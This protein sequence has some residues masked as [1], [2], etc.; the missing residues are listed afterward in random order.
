MWSSTYIPTH[1]DNKGTRPNIYNR[2]RPRD[3]HFDTRGTEENPR[4]GHYKMS[5][6]WV[7][8]QDKMQGIVHRTLPRRF[9]GTEGQQS[10]HDPWVWTG[11]KKKRPLF[12]PLRRRQVKNAVFGKGL[13]TQGVEGWTMH[14]TLQTKQFVRCERVQGQGIQP[15]IHALQKSL[16]S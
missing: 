12:C 5:S 2:T 7:Y 15:G 14:G 8:K 11:S 10:L 13:Q 3:H 1:I 9:E 16:P 4:S 6:T